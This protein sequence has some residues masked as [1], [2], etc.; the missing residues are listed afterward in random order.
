MVRARQSSVWIDSYQELYTAI[1]AAAELLS[2]L[3]AIALTFASFDEALERY[4]NDCFRI[5][6]LYRRFT[7]ARRTFEGPNPLDALLRDRVEKRYNNKFVYELGNAWQKQVD[8][9][10]R[11]AS[12]TLR[13][14]RSFYDHYVQQLVR[15]DKKAVVIVS[16]A[17]RYEVAE[18]LGSRIRQEDRPD[19]L[20]YEFYKEPELFWRIADSNEVM[21]PSE[22]V[23][24]RGSVIGIPPKE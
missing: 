11:W 9:T 3:S 24:E 10:E 16:D 21:R 14:Q 22:L 7:Y 17:L 12:S 4:R 1:A 20:A 6:Q 18:E 19:L 15:D 23:A 5:D 8:A 2:E 13:S